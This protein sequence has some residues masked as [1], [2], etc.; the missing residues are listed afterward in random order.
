MRRHRM[1]GTAA[2]LGISAGRVPGPAASARL[3]RS[4][5]LRR[6]ASHVE[7]PVLIGARKAA[8]VVVDIAAL[9][10][11]AAVDRIAVAAVARSTVAVAP[12]TA[13]T[14]DSQPDNDLPSAR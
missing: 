11:L 1:A 9:L 5:R 10:H 3:P 4:M 14:A 12:T 6:T 13:A 7:I 2:V 8:A